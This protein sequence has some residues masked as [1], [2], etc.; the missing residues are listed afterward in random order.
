LANA[1]LSFTKDGNKIVK[2]SAFKVIPEFL[3]NYESITMPDKLMEIY[4][5]LMDHEINSL[6][7]R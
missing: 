6:V 7:S 1:L 3:A 4:L 2:V 5:K